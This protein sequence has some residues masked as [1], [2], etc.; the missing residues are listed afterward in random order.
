MSNIYLSVG[1]G[2]RINVIVIPPPPIQ[3]RDNVQSTENLIVIGVP[4]S[5]TSHHIEFNLW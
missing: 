2:I 3:H 1:G 4:Q 5:Y